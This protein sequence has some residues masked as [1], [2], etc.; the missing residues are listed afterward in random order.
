MIFPSNHLILFWHIQ[1]VGPETREP[2]Y[3]WD[4]GPDI[5]DTTG[6]IRDVRPKTFIERGTL[7]P[8]PRTIKWNPRPKSNQK[9]Q[10]V[11]K[12]FLKFLNYFMI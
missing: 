1:K 5:Q 11:T 8:G 9:R 7:D 6:G 3:G 10:K 4:A 2:S 12:G